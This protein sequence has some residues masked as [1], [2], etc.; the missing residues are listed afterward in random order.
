MSTVLTRLEEGGGSREVRDGLWQPSTGRIM[1]TSASGPAGVRGRLVDDGSLEVQRL[2]DGLL[3][4]PLRLGGVTRDMVLGGECLLAGPGGRT[5][6]APP[7]IEVGAGRTRVRWRALAA[8]SWALRLALP[9]RPADEPSFRN[10]HARPLTVSGEG[11]RLRLEGAVYDGLPSLV[12]EVEASPGTVLRQAARDDPWETGRL[13]FERSGAAVIEDSFFGVDVTGEVTGPR[14]WI[15]LSVTLADPGGL[16][17]RPAEAAVEDCASRRW[18][19]LLGPAV[20]GAAGVAELLDGVEQRAAGRPLWHGLRGLGRWH[21]ADVDPEVVG[22]ESAALLHHLLARAEVAA[23]DG[24]RRA[25]L[26]AER[27]RVAR[28]IDESFW[29]PLSRRHRDSVRLDAGSDPRSLALTPA[30]ILAAGLHGAPLSRNQRQRCVRLTEQRLLAPG[31]VRGL[32]P[33]DDGFDPACPGRGLLW[34]WLLEPFT[35]ASL[36]AFG[37]ERGRQRAL[38]QV[39]IEIEGAPEAWRDDGEVP[40]PVGDMPSAR[41]ARAAR[42]IRRWLAGEEG[43]VAG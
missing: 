4:A 10:E 25:A 43:P 9:C 28:W 11:E 27:R 35:R 3:C 39:A 31:G 16:A 37:P 30:L 12:I 36:L 34:P 14:G 7:M 26:G 24:G 29:I 38:R 21:G 23:G 1:R 2:D 6:G 13:R 33:T 42:W 20:R 17:A 22:F 18:H 5:P 15:S 40:V 41:S 32:D 19:G 8:G